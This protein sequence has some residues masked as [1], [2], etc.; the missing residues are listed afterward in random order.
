MAEA[1]EAKAAALAASTRLRELPVNASNSREESSGASPGDDLPT[2]DERIAEILGETPTNESSGS[3]QTS[4]KP[5]I[6]SLLD[7]TH[8]TTTID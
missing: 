4:S 1:E 7:V 6:P 2:L 5:T 8:T 3:H